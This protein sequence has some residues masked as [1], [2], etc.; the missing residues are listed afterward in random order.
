MRPTRAK[1]LVYDIYGAYVRQLGGRIAVADLI[2]L[3]A[4][5]GVDEQVVRS[6]VSRMTKGGMLV[7][8]RMAGRAGY[9][10]SPEAAVMLAE[11]DASIYGGTLPAR[12]EEGWVLVTFTV[13]EGMRRYRHQ[14][15]S[16]LTWL[17]Y[18]NLG[19]GVWIA[20]RRAL[21]RTV[22][23]VRRLGLEAFVDV[24]EAHHEAFRG[25]I[26]LVARCWELDVIG[27][28]YERLVRSVQ[29]TLARW[30]SASNRPDD[31]AAFVDHTLVLHE[32]R[33]LP[34]LDPGLPPELLPAGWQG[35]VA[36]RLFAEVSGLLGD[37]ALRYV[38]SVVRGKR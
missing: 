21:E 37:A 29:P 1:S 24:F 28:R 32:W 30:R 20:P 19:G 7:P 12:L 10:L 11:G 6:S 22:E 17:G 31:R 13:P 18:G 35:Q 25:P 14:L 16:R 23:A 15:R 2:D 27:A 36:A 34:F 38:A 8:C 4:L 3:L 9:E 33:K 26:E 5:L